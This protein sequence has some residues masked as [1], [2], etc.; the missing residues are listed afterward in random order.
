MRE[1]SRLAVSISNQRCEIR[2]NMCV[3]RM[4]GCSAHLFFPLNNSRQPGH[5]CQSSIRHIRC[6]SLRL[7]P[8]LQTRMHSWTQWTKPMR[9][10]V[11]CRAMSTSCRLVTWRCFYHTIWILPCWTRRE[12]F[13]VIYQLSGKHR[14]I[15]RNKRL[16]CWP[17]TIPMPTRQRS[18]TSCAPAE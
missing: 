18:V 8:G 4:R 12:R 9:R 7:G 6:A 13:S 10:F 17:N 14:R 3:H 15:Q 2:R 5:S 16:H 1:C 11:G